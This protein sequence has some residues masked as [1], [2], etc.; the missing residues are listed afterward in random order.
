MSDNSVIN[1][2]A[3]AMSESVCP[4]NRLA[5]WAFRWSLLRGQLICNQ[6]QASQSASQC[7]DA[8]CHRQGCSAGRDDPYP[9]RELAGLLGRVGLPVRL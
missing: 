2:I 6:C 3:A 7:C 8:F 1:E 9:W 4:G 5:S